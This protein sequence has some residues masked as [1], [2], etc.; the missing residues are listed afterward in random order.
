LA[1]RYADI[2]RWSV[3]WVE[4]GS[5][6]HEIQKD[7]IDRAQQVNEHFGIN[8]GNEF[9][10]RHMAIVLNFQKNGH[11]Y[12]VVPITTY[13][14]AH[15]LDKACVVVEHGKQHGIPWKSSI[16]ID[17]IRQIDKVRV[18]NIVSSY[19]QKTLQDKVAGAI[20]ALFCKGY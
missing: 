4:F 9:S 13:L 14:D 11:T 7:E 10:Y 2:H 6:K 15:A 5:P 1:V 17:A 3:V 16:K 8:L 18:K 19:L 20:D 12:V